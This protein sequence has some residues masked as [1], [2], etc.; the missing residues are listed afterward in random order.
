MKNLISILTILISTS[1][2]G[3]VDSYGRIDYQKFDKKLFDSLMLDEV[4]HRRVEMKLT[5]L[6]FDS[7]CFLSA[8]YQARVMTFKN[9]IKQIHDVNLDGVKLSSPTDRFEYFNDINQVLIADK[10]QFI[11][12]NY[13]GINIGVK[14]KTFTYERLVNFL[15]DEFFVG[16]EITENLYSNLGSK[17]L[18]CAF[19]TELKLSDDGYVYDIF[20][21]NVI[22]SR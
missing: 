1:V 3:Q 7:I 5:P 15:L 13:I 12:E 9:V 11:C 17:E 6:I 21:T 20:V 8:N 18:Y 22:A 19:S 16:N 10:K 14:S 2:F 4:N